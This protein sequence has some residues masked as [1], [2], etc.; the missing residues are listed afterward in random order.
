[1]MDDRLRFYRLTRLFRI[2]NEPRS[3]RNTHC[4]VLGGEIVTN[5]SL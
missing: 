1:M 3:Y 5:P 2:Y 4:A